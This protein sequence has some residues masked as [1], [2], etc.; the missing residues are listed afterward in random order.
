MSDPGNKH[1]Q[2]A[3]RNVV[4]SDLRAAVAD[5]NARRDDIHTLSP[6]AGVPEGDPEDLLGKH[7]TAV[8]KLNRILRETVQ[9]KLRE[10]LPGPLTQGNNAYDGADPAHK[11]RNST[12]EFVHADE[13]NKSPIV[14]VLV[15]GWVK[16]EVGA[17]TYYSSSSSSSSI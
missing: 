17:P 4:V 15:R 9:P 12:V 16:Y 5:V 6:L 3:I 10:G 7:Q 8:D 1:F 13:S 11:I 14:G 2:M